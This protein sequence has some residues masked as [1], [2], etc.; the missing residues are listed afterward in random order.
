MQDP[1]VPYQV[2]DE[3][4]R[5]AVV[6][7]VQVV[8]TDPEVLLADAANQTVEVASDPERASAATFH[9]SLLAAGGL[10]S[11]AVYSTRTV[12]R[13]ANAVDEFDDLATLP[14]VRVRTG[15]SGGI[16]PVL[17]GQAGET[18]SSSLTGFP[19]NTVRIPSAS[20]KREFR[21]PDHMD[22][23]ERYIA[24]TKNVNKQYLSSQLLDDIAW[25]QRGGRPGRVDLIIDERTGDYSALAEGTPEPW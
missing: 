16:E 10:S 2:F 18:V 1:T 23:L 12:R 17:A 20:G 5:S 4:V 7:S 21:I 11:R 9:A 13:F 14:A 24:E 19:K 8:T 15:G 6:T 25:V 22:D 3:A